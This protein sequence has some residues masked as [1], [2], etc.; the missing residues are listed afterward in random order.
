M[1]I[2]IIGSKGFIGSHLSAYLTQKGN[3]IYEAD[4][5]VDYSK[6]EGY[7]LIDAS[8]SDYKEIFK[9]HDF[10]IC[11]NCSGAAS[12]LES[13]KNP[14]RDY[15][16]N[17]VNVFRILDAIKEYQD[18]CKFIN[19]S[20]AAVY[21]NPVSLPIEESATLDPI[22]P[23]GLHKLMAEQICEEF[24]RLYGIPT[25]S[26]RLFS[27]YGIGL[28]KQLFWDLYQKARSGQTVNLFGTGK[29]SRDFIYI[30][31]LVKAIELIIKKA[32]FTADTINVA[33]GI[34]IRIEEAVSVFFSYFEG[35]ME[36]TF[37]GEER[38][39]DPINWRADLHKL[40]GMGY[41]PSYNLALGL[42]EYYEWIK[43]HQHL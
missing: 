27:V 39:G 15:F 32:D 40:S 30:A 21:G 19:L 42:K 43:K 36:Y 14:V 6:R 17:T 16:L 10:D 1:K 35:G 7:F 41:N 5:V 22:S 2:I 25:C 11:I 24:Y 26:L 9:H 28:Q 37:T 12:V 3:T 13:L 38:E 8:N 23:Y 18:S 33:N 20:S 34:E 29:E 4:V 31:D